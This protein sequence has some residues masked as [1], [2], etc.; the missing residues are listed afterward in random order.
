MSSEASEHGEDIACFLCGGSGKLSKDRLYRE[1]GIRQL[2]DVAKKSVEETLEGLNKDG[3]KFFQTYKDELAKLFEERLTAQLQAAEARNARDCERQT[4]E[5]EKLQKQVMDLAVKI[6]SSDGCI[7]E[8]QEELARARATPA[9]KGERGE[10]DF[11]E[12]IQQRRDLR[13]SAKLSKA[14]DYLLSVQVDGA[15]GTPNWLN[16]I[17]LVDVKKDKAIGAEEVNDLVR[18][19]ATRKKKIGFL[20]ATTAEQLKAK[21]PVPPIHERNGIFIVRV[22]MEE[23]PFYVDLLRP[24][25]Q[26]LATAKVEEGD[27]AWKAKFN[28][29]VSEVTQAF[30][31][32]QDVLEHTRKIRD[33]VEGIEKVVEK[34]K[35]RLQAFCTTAV[36]QVA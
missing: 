36:A 20:V 9:R 25:L 11:V 32:V 33:Q 35:K 14:G 21:D 34:V 10:V 15:D 13:V 18:D 16:E 7:K 6:G 22:L 31:Q 19:T 2:A 28:A 27:E 1:L 3:F 23:F 26:L 4:E 29:I 30:I 8:L 17:A 5:K 24:F 12:F